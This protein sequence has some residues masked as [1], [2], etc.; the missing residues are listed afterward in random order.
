[1]VT[2]RVWSRS[3]CVWIDR[4]KVGRGSVYGT[5][6]YNLTSNL[7]GFVDTFI[8]VIVAQVEFVKVGHGSKWVRTI[9][10]NYWLETYNFCT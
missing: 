9:T 1:M 7:D 4:Q 10:G 2:G 3:G 8:N 6:F 5:M